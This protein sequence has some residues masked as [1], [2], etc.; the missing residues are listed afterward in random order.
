MKISKKVP[1]IISLILITFLLGSCASS[2][3]LNKKSTTVQTTKP[4]VTAITPEKTTSTPAAPAILPNTPLFT[5]VFYADPSAHVFNGKLYIYPSHDIENNIK[6]DDNG[7]QYAMED[8][9]VL[10]IDD[11]NSACIDNG[12]ALHMKDVPWVKRQMWAPDAAYKNGKYYLYFPAKD[13]DDIFR[14]G[15]ATSSSPTGPFTAE[16]NY[17]EGSF[18]MDPAVFT[19]S[20]GKSYMYFG[21]LMGGQLQNWATGKFD[22]NAR[23]PI[24]SQV[25]LVPKI[26]ELNDDMLSFKAQPK[27]ISIVDE[28][29]KPLIAKDEKRRFFEAV[30]VHKYND[31]YY[32]SYS[33]GTTHYIAY[34]MSKSPTGPFT[35]KGV[36]LEPVKKGWTTHHSIVQFNDKWYLF[37]HDATVSGV[38]NKRSLKYSELEYNS[39]GTIKTITP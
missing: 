24:G 7:S 9:H 32:L 15:V 8:Y 31:N 1:V 34:A 38:D 20:D 6:P 36:I 13:K 2:D 14:I 17:I 30:W 28:N 11:F 22:K 18:S 10:S 26:A 33:T 27:D 16:K 5:D 35:Y 39:D 19:D 4:E 21:G 23:L 3:E 29:G 12:Q 37:Y 25:A